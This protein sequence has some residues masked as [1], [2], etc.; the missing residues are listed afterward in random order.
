MKTTRLFAIT[1]T[2]AALLSCSKEEVPDAGKD[3]GRSKLTI[4]LKGEKKSS[5]LT[6]R[7]AGT[8]TQTEESTINDFIIYVFKQSGDNDIA[9]KAVT[10][11]SAA[12][13]TVADMEISI[14]AKEVY[15]VANT[16]S[17]ATM[18]TALMAVTKMSEL[19]AITGRLFA[20]N[21]ASGASTQTL[22]NLWMSGSGSITPV[23]AGN[24]KADIT[25]SYVPARL[26]ITSVTISN[27]NVPNFSTDLVLNEIVI[28]NAGGATK[29]VPATGATSLIPSFTASA[30][31]P[32]YI[33]GMDMTGMSNLPTYY[34]QN[35]ALKLALTGSPAKIDASN[36]QN[37][38]YVFENDG[39]LASFE[40]KPT[41]ISLKATYQGTRTVYYSVLFKA[42]ADGSLG[43][44][45]EIVERGK[46]YDIA[47]TIKK[48]GNSEPTIPAIKTTVEVTI[49]PASWQ[50]VTIDKVYE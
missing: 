37:Y 4:S 46:S 1:M 14:D 35:N 36:N 39:A 22:S 45:D 5:A 38:F 6:G 28:L 42:D 21:T 41:V 2:A 34:G 49:T 43:Y 32:F 47:M 19:Q 8:P 20:D 50:T 44:D 30:T 7:A 13:L 11:N 31:T 3:A 17:A 9:P 27:D 40:G 15:V 10:V 48:L 12:D 23:E 26:R 16:A 18:Q 25:L 33:S 24:I 29:L